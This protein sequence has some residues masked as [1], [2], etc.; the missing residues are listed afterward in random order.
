MR[1]PYLFE[2]IETALSAV[3][4]LFRV[5]R[6]GRGKCGSDARVSNDVVEEWIDGV[7]AALRGEN[8]SD[9]LQIHYVCLLGKKRDGRRE[10]ADF[11]DAR[12]PDDREERPTFE[13]LLNRLA[14]GRAVF[15]LYHF[16]TVDHEPV[17]GEVKEKVRKLLEELLARGRTVLVGCSSGKGRT[18]E[19]LR[20]C[21]WA[22]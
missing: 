13:E 5:S 15:T 9:R 16:P 21:R 11:Y 14:G 1:E 12:A 8:A 22:L 19:V 18:M 4:R 10:I 6:P 2:K 7:C 3:G 17:P 20:S